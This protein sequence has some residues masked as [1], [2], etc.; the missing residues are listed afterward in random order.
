MKNWQTGLISLWTKYKYFI[1]VIL[2]G[3]LLLVS[4]GLP[5]REEADSGGETSQAFDLAAFQQMVADS[6][7][8]IEGAGRVE[9]LFSLESGEEAVYASD[10]NRSSQTASDGSSTSESYQSAMSILSDGSY[11][12]SP[13]LLTSRYP[14]FR[15]AVVLC[16]GADNSAVR[17]AVTQAISA[18]CGLSSDRISISKISQ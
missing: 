3:A 10:V 7:S 1:A 8:N 4:S 14:T 2:A 5:E 12:E 11:G 15:G 6:L 18:L 9:V 17:L 16:D 13:V